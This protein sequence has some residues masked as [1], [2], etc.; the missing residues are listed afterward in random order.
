MET[1]RNYGTAQVQA[2]PAS[3]RDRLAAQ[4]LDLSLCV[5]L[6]WYVGIA[7]ARRYGG[8]GISADGLEFQGKPALLAGAVFA[9]GTFLYFF[10]FEAMWGATVGKLL[11]GLAVQS[12]GHH[13]CS[14]A[15]ALVR[16]MLRPIDALFGLLL[17]AISEQR[18]TLGDRVGGTTVIKR[19]AAHRTQGSNPQV[20]ESQH[21]GWEA[22]AKA[23]VIDL[24]LLTLFVTAYL[25]ATGSVLTA[26]QLRVNV[27]GISL[28]VLMDL[29]FFYFVAFEGVLGGTVGKLISKLRVVRADGKPCGF[30]GSTIKGI[31]RPVDL[32]TGGLL[33][34]LLVRYTQRHQNLGDRLAGT[35]VVNDE[36]QNRA[37]FWSATA[38]LSAIGGLTA[39]PFLSHAAL[40]LPQLVR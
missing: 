37:A 14:I 7:I 20:Y 4:I 31:W 24:T 35:I 32:C 16:N 27:R 15:S 29:V 12:H 23:A 36:S 40:H 5:L 28:L 6:F 19:F 8:I 30:V 26:G 3:I 1:T 11:C 38:L 33:P 22:R 2:Q 13:R 34:S 25:F 10:L 17:M 9:G 21:A 39:Y 18:A